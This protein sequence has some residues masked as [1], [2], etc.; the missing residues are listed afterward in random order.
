MMIPAGHRV[1][2]RM[3]T[4]ATAYQQDVP[5]WLARGWRVQQVAH[6]QVP[7]NRTWIAI[8]ALVSAVVIIP[9]MCCGL[10]T[11]GVLTIVGM[12]LLILLLLFVVVALLLTNEQTRIV[13]TYVW[14]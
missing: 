14:P 5:Q 1:E 10:L 2:T 11:F 6:Q 4:S 9:M 12:F 3:Y 8:V 13:A 7:P